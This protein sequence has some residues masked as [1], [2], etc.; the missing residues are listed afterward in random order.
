MSQLDSRINKLRVVY[1]RR[2]PP[3]ERATSFDSMRLTFAEQIELSDLLRH[4]APL[5]GERWDFDALSVEQLARAAE[6]TNKGEG[7]PPSP[8]YHYMKHRD[9]GIGPC[10]CAACLAN[11]A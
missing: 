1:R 8:A 7:R 10:L 2:E 3:P 6:L 4:V 11:D 9:P 5:P